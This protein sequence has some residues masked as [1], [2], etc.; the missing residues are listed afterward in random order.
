[1]YDFVCTIVLGFKEMTMHSNECIIQP[2]TS[3]YLFSKDIS[4]V[5]YC[6]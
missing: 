3:L 5:T 2:C 6:Y 4:D 1:M